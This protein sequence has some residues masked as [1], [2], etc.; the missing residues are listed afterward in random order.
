MLS[1]AYR[2]QINSCLCSKFVIIV[3]D[4]NHDNYLFLPFTYDVLWEHDKTDN[5]NRKTPSVELC[6]LCAPDV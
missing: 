5:S 3:E 2:L 6:S 4:N 1:Y